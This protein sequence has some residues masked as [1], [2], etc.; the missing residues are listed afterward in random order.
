[1]PQTVIRPEEDFVEGE[2]DGFKVRRDQ[3]LLFDGKGGDET[4]FT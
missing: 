2:R 1:M 3:F 4:V